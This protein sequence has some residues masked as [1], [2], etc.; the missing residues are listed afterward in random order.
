MIA[1]QD[2]FFTSKFYANLAQMVGDFRQ[3]MRKSTA[4]RSIASPT[5]VK[6][7]D[8]LLYRVDFSGVG[9]YRATFTTESRCHAVSFNLTANGPELL[10]DVAAS[11]DKLSLADKRNSGPPPPYCIAN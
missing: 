8:R 1:A 4:W 6:V 10:A 9:L 5:E 2:M 3:A 7:T 11:V